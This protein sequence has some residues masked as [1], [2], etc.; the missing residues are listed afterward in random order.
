MDLNIQSKLVSP[1]KGNSLF[2]VGVLIVVILL[3]LY[4][5]VRPKHQQAN[6]KVAELANAQK[7]YSSVETDRKTLETLV[8][9]LKDKQD[10]I[11]VLD[12]AIPLNG[13]ITSLDL[14]IDNM[15]ANSGMKLASI[16]NSET[17]SGVVAGD[18]KLLDDPYGA[19]RTLQSS[20]V[21]ITVTGPVE[22]FNQL[23]KLIENSPRLMDIDSVTI[24]QEQE[25]LYKIRLK[26]YY[27][28][29]K[30]SKTADQ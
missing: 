6:A 8:G 10:E 7:Q 29:P 4:F 11:E 20:V 2:E 12:Q 9:Q 24:S 13:R 22:Q 27:Y 28:A 3:V 16:I 26:A 18:K 21:N 14:V 1:R 15:V 25:V 19:D 30:Y 5:I 17:E 23:L